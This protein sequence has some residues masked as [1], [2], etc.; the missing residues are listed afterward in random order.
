M[1]PT[2][3]SS[4]GL[5]LDAEGHPD[6]DNS[7]YDVFNADRSVGVQVD[8]TGRARAVLLAPSVRTMNEIALQA[9]IVRV[10]RVAAVRAS[11]AR[12]RRAQYIFAIED[13]FLDPALIADCATYEQYQAEWNSNFA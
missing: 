12:R 7:R 4:Y 6:F 5:P 11:Y 3:P 9:Q 8:I 2:D 13:R 1:R 10:S